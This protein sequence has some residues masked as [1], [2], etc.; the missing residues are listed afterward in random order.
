MAR[1]AII[2]PEAV[3]LSWARRLHD[4]GCEVSYYIDPPFQRNVGTNI[5]PKVNSLHQLFAWAKEKP[6]IAL[7][8][9]SGMGKRGPKVPVGADDFRKAGVPTICGGSFC[10]RL[11]KDRKFGEKIAQIIGCHIPPTKQFGSVSETIAFAQTIGKDKW[12]F[13]SDKYLESDA[14]HG[15][16]GEEMVRYLTHLRA[17][18]GDAI[19]NIMQ[20]SVPGVA[21]STACWW[22]GRSFVPPYEATIEHKKFMDGDVG[23]STG[24]CFNAVWF[25]ES[26]TPKIVKSLKWDALGPIFGRFEAPPGLYDINAI[27]AEKS[28][29]WGPA[30]EAYFLEW[31]PRLGWDS[32][33]TSHRLLEIPMCDFLEKL[34]AGR[35]AEAPFSTKDISYS[36]RLSVSPY[37][38]EHNEDAKKTCVGTPIYGVDGVWDKH[39]IGYSVAVND[40]GE[41]Y[42]ADRNGLVGCSLAT[43]RKLSE[44]HDEVQ[45]YAKDE[46]KG[47]SFQFRTDGGKCVAKDAAGVQKIGFEVH[48]GLLR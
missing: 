39:F 25:Y 47:A 14:T 3:G 41:V 15:G 45:A 29:P 6:T 17:K 5:A 35:L 27:I 46:L 28:G 9:S 1:F 22:N 32:E 8:M 4:E 48:P 20:Q 21:I 16:D 40:E 23:P 26:E 18:Y 34:V 30:G 31:T 24:A 2:D 42:V 10:D 12:Y 11:E 33:A 37:P 43:G 7:F 38:W 36:T 44:L 19:P 13:K